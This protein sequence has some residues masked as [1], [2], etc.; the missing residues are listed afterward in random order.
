MTELERQYESQGNAVGLFGSM[1]G[2]TQAPPG[3]AGPS[4]TERLTELNQLKEAGL[5]NDEEYAAKKK[6]IV[7]SL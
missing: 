4:V 7:E 2:S 6:A 3:S 5:L 1:F